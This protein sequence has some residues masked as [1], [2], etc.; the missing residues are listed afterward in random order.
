MAHASQNQEYPAIDPLPK[1]QL[2]RESLREALAFFRFIRPYRGQFYAG[3]FTLFI[4]ALMSLAF[5][6]LAGA[7]IDAALR[8]GVTTL[9]FL[10]VLSLNQVAFLLAGSV[11]I[12]ALGSYNSSLAF[13]RVGLSALADLRR[14]AYGRLIALP[15]AFF[16]QRRVGELT[17]RVSMDIAQIERA[18]IDSVPQIIRQSVFLLGGIALFAS[19]Y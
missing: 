2:N 15:M 13:N 5:P 19:P 10:G 8:S 7:I 1:A 12:L 6:I 16:G 11:T 17:S 9:P 3:L 14:E 4:S 18:L